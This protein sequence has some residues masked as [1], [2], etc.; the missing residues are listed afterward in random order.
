MVTGH[1]SRGHTSTLGSSHALLLLS[2]S[3]ALKRAIGQEI[4]A[5]GMQHEWVAGRLT[6]LAG[7][8]VEALVPRDTA[9]VFSADAGSSNPDRSVVVVPGSSA[10]SCEKEESKPIVQAI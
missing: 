1:Q 5:A 9:S 4:N 8:I 3:Q 2:S 7:L 10:P 6:F